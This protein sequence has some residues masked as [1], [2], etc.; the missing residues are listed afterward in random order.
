MGSPAKN[1]AAGDLWRLLPIAKVL[2]LYLHIT[3]RSGTMSLLGMQGPLVQD[4]AA[5]VDRTSEVVSK[6]EIEEATMATGAADLDSGNTTALV[7][8]SIDGIEGI[9]ITI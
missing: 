9:S 3:R 4:S 8:D 6:V 7:E 1:K 2:D 5:H